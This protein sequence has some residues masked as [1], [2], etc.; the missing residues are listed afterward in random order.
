MKGR[1]ET[2]KK[3]PAEKI[4]IVK[5]KRKEREK[6]ERE[7]QDTKIQQRKRKVCGNDDFCEEKKRTR[8]K[9]VRE[10]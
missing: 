2:A 8:E 3:T 7:N 5:E 6:G 10:K 9:G 1:R 4:T